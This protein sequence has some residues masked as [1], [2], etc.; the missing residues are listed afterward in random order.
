M[1]ILAIDIGTTTGWALGTRDGKVRSGSQ[2][3]AAVRNDGPGQRWL[4]FRNFLTETGRT[5]GEVHAVYYEDV[6]NHAGVLASHIYGGFVAHLQYWCEINRI[7]C[8]PVGVGQVKKH[9]TGAGNAKKEAMIETARAKG[10]QVVD[11]NHA[12]ALAILSL[13]RAIEGGMPLPPA[14]RKKP[15]PSKKPQPALLA[16]AI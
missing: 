2:S 15:V 11:D 8:H 14:K 1:N 6:K 10:H 3:F 13:A 5:A 7:P 16:E 9:W 4:K 12:D